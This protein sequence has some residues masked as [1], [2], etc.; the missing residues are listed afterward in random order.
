MTRRR[1]GGFS[2]GPR[3]MPPPGEKGPKGGRPRRGARD[4][5]KRGAEPSLEQP[6]AESAGAVPCRICGYPVDPKR[7]HFHMVRFHGAALRSPPP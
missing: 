3:G 2:S 1:R 5:R 6:V 7:M 4:T